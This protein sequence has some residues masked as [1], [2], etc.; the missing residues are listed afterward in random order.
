MCDSHVEDKSHGN[1]KTTKCPLGIPFLKP[2]FF[3]FLFLVYF[4]SN[5]KFS[6][7]EKIKLLGFEHDIQN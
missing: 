6:K 1:S 3:S 5:H 4:I 7:A 2:L